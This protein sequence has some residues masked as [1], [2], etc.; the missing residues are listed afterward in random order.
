MIITITV[1]AQV[2]HETRTIERQTQFT[3]QQWAASPAPSYSIADREIGRLKAAVAE[4]LKATT[5]GPARLCTD[6]KI[7]VRKL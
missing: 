5:G 3:I 4:E 1:S 2:P 6:G 7:R